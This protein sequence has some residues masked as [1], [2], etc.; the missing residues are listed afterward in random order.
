MKKTIPLLLALSIF[1]LPV[2]PIRAQ[3]EEVVH[4]VKK[5]DTLWDISNKYMKTPWNWPLIW[6]NNEAITNPHLIYPGDKVI[7]TYKD[8]AYQITIVPADGGEPK[9]YTLPEIAD[10]T[11]KTMVLSPNYACYMYKDAKYAGEGT[12]VG[13]Q[14]SGAFS[15]VNDVIL[16]KMTQPTTSKGVAIVTPLSV[17]K[18]KKTVVGYVYKIIG[19]ASIVDTPSGF[20][21]ARV[22]YANQEIKTGDIVTDNFTTLQPLTVQLSQPTLTSDAVIIDFLGGVAG[23]SAADIV[24]TDI[25]ASQGLLPGSLVNIYKP[26]VIKGVGTIDDYAGLGLVIQALDQSAMVVVL[27]SKD[28]LKKGY[29]VRAK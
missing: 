28:I 9:V 22:T 1:C 14:E 7:I 23:S 13:K 25:G 21:R 15:S 5:G 24:F 19:L 4:T 3:D 12:V 27:E 18:N 11:G 26:H 17:I 6:S 2:L 16:I 10:Q 20:V 8:G 29:P